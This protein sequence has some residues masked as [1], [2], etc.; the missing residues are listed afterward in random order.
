MTASTIFDTRRYSGW[1]DEIQCNCSTANKEY[2]SELIEWIS[3]DL[4]SETSY[5]VM[6]GVANR[7]VSSYVNR[8]CHGGSM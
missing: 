7:I 3:V 1:M 8:L 6:G 5:E 2:M 4:T